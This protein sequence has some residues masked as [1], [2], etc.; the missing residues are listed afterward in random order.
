MKNWGNWSYGEL[1]NVIDE[2]KK[3]G[4]KSIAISQEHT[5][6]QNDQQVENWLKKMGLKYN[7]EME[8]TV[9]YL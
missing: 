9:I 5:D 8:R 2:A 3:E 1:Q 7:S 6:Y 4:R